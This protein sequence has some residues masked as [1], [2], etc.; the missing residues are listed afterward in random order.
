MVLESIHL[1]MT[2]LQNGN[3]MIMRLFRSTW[4]YKHNRTHI[5]YITH[6]I[7]GKLDSD[8]SAISSLN[9]NCLT[10]ARATFLVLFNEYS[11]QSIFHVNSKPN[12]TIFKAL[13][14]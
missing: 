12:M 14:V 1:C 4:V 8:C 7:C 2:C 5:L 11:Y 6:L 10:G 9:N 3:N 13:G